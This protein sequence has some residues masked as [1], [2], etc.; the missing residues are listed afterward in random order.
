MSRRERDIRDRIR[1]RRENRD[2]GW[3]M[4]LG[5]PIMREAIWELYEVCMEQ[6]DVVRDVNG[7]TSEPDT[8]RAIGK[9]AVGDWLDNRLKLADHRNWLLTQAEHDEAIDDGRA[10][11]TQAEPSP[12]EE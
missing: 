7:R 8:F 12:E 11:E 1:I 5:D 10:E 2:R 3:K 9:R 4:I 6:R